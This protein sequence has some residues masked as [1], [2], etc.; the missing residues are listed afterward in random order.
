MS[1]V[2][3]V[4][5]GVLVKAQREWDAGADK[6]DGAWRRLH[7]AGTGGL[8][9]E[10]VAAVEAFREPRVDEIKAAGR[11]AQGYADE[12]RAFN[13]QLVHTD[14]EQAEKIRALLPWGDH[15]AEIVG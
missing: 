10:V 1:V 11:Q 5:F 13:V 4:P 6:L 3:N 2:L 9:A 8:S 7:K 14:V 15:A 12:V